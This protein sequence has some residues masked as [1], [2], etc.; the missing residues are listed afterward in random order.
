MS[1][2]HL[3]LLEI[4]RQ[5]ESHTVEFKTEL[6]PE[7]LL[8]EA[9]AAFAN[10]LGG[11]LV[12]GVSKTG[13]LLGLSPAAGEE[14]YRRLEEVIRSLFTGIEWHI[15]KRDIDGKTIVFAQVGAAPEHA[16]PVVTSRGKILIRRAGSPAIVEQQER[17]VFAPRSSKKRRVFVAMSFR[18][19]EEP[20]L[21]DYWQAMRR[22][23]LA[24]KLPLELFRIDLR[25]GDYEISA[26]IMAELDK[27]DL[28]IADFTLN[29]KNVYFELG[30]ARG[31][32]K[33]L[34]Q[35]ARKDT[36]LEFDVRNWRTLFYRNA[37]ELEHKLIA[38][39]NEAYLE[40]DGRRTAG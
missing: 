11:V 27:A 13:E 24:T 8:A 5:G 1:L 21:V 23:A 12:I 37:T 15:G 30:Y 19:E 4:I 16:R 35:T 10:S 38:A 22:A 28:I 20:S 14:A 9:L 39:L 33:R 26:E 25:E 6:P 18:E 32:G 36:T 2:E 3:N 34:I 29:S 31:R 17:T 7:H 40:I